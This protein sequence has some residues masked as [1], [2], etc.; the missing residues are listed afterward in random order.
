MKKTDLA[1][2]AGYLEGK[3][4]SVYVATRKRADGT[5]GP[6]GCRIAMAA[7]YKK[8]PMLKRFADKIGIKVQSWN[9]INGF[10]ETFEHESRPA[11]YT[12]VKRPILEINIS[13]LNAHDLITKIAPYLSEDT[14]DKL[15]PIMKY[16]VSAN[17]L[18][19]EQTRGRVPWKKSSNMKRNF[20]PRWKK[21]A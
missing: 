10:G 12:D 14:L 7:S 3:G 19:G 18:K 16:Q 9:T 1:W 21:A 5:R 2:I 6:N 4:F 20:N 13:T 8:Q 15:E 11:V 17:N